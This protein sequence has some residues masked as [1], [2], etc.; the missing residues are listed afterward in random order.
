MNEILSNSLQPWND[1]DQVIHSASTVIV[2]STDRMIER[3]K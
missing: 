1:I 2:T 3:L